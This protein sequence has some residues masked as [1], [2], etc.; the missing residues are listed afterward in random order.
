M[1]KKKVNC[2]KV[3]DELLSIITE[4]KNSLENTFWNVC[5]ADR[6]GQ[7]SQKMNKKKGQVIQEK[8][9]KISF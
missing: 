2:H 8:I 3:D 6:I 9:N 5:V 4:K 7:R 1:W